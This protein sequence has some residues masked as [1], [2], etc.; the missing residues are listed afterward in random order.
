MNEIVEVSA[1]RMGMVVE[2]SPVR[3]VTTVI[4]RVWNTLVVD[5]STVHF[6][7]TFIESMR[8]NAPNTNFNEGV[9]VLSAV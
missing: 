2:A 7:L 4:N 3:K 8:S 6:P 9:Q 5:T 1:A